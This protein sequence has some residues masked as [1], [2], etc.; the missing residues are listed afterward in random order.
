[1]K[2]R[3]LASN[4]FFRRWLCC[5]GNR[6]AGLSPFFQP[7][8]SMRTKALPTASISLFLRCWQA[9]RVSG[10]SLGVNLVLEPG[11]H[12]I[13]LEVD[14]VFDITNLRICFFALVAMAITP[15]LRTK[16]VKKRT[17]RFIRHQSD[18]YD[19]LK[20]GTQWMTWSPSWWKTKG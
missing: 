5:H 15:V 18:R 1:M 11:S 17:K 19:R 6:W 3:E 7:F 10:I 2:T 14:A 20:V 9:W 16:I 12:G 8:S 4:Y 13:A